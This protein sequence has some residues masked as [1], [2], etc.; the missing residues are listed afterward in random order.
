MSVYEEYEY[1]EWQIIDP[2]VTSYESIISTKEYKLRLAGIIANPVYVCRVIS[3]VKKGDK[4]AFMQH[5]R[6]DFDLENLYYEEE[7]CDY[8]YDSI[9]Q[10]D[11]NADRAEFIVTRD[12]K[13]LLVKLIDHNIYEE[14]TIDVEEVLLLEALEMMNEEKMYVKYFDE[15]IGYD[16]IKKELIQI[17][18]LVRNRHVYEQLG[19]K[20]LSGLLL[21]GKPGL[22]K[23][24][25][26]ECFIAAC[27]LKS[28]TVRKKKRKQEF[29]YEITRTFKDAKE[30]AP[31]IILLD[32][33]DKFAN[34]DDHHKDSEEFVAVQAGIDEVKGKDV[35]VIATVNEYKKL[36]ESLCRAGRFDRK[37]K[38]SAPDGEDLM[39]VVS[40]YLK[41]KKV[42][43][44]LNIQDLVRMVNCSSCAEL[45][46][47]INEAALSAGFQR[48][49]E[50]EM[51]DIITAVLKEQYNISNSNIGVADEYVRK[52]A[53]H[54][55][56]HLVVCEI[57][58][59][60]S[61]GMASIR[62]R[63]NSSIGGF[64]HRCEGFSRRK[65]YILAA[66]G[67]KAAVELYYA[68]S[69][70]SG[71]DEDIEEAIK[72]IR[73]GA[74]GNASLGF[75][76]AQK[77]AY[78]EDTSNFFKDGLETVIQSELER[79]YLN[80]KDILLQNRDFLETIW[81]ALMEKEILLYSDIQKIKEG[82]Y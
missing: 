27:G 58:S 67:G 62:S 71:C 38:F 41:N 69:I 55:A 43:K 17:C 20:Q 52:N 28:Y 70:A 12:G 56:G 53:L 15:V 74:L 47:I 39:K 73:R 60:G 68:D 79:Y 37:I 13:T 40:H 23:T 33:L 76:F 63:G 3:I 8:V 6:Y 31:C 1:E 72:Y 45:E 29:I 65:Q 21:Y 54:E 16:D 59:P 44:D 22:G 46:A 81:E 75:G 48:K 34:D 57:L 10:Y 19:A 32:D 25:I 4:Y 49:K 30:N 78:Y 24:L 50:I 77:T 5:T 61:I 9:Q 64:V 82:I 14:T 42:S 7:L 11:E 51:E 2:P 66:L 36:P 35:L 80:T 26:A 18:D